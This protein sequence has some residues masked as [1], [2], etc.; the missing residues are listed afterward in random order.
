M[1]KPKMYTEK[2]KKRWPGPGTVLFLA[3]VFAYLLG[4]LSG[5]QLTR[6]VVLCQDKL[7]TI[8]EG[9]GYVGVD[10]DAEGEH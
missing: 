10:K 7:I 9:S 5:I 8:L 4:I 3:I 1:L 6:T 2:R